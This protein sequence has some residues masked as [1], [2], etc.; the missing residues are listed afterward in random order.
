[1][2]KGKEIRRVPIDCH[3]DTRP[4]RSTNVSRAIDVSTIAAAATNSHIAVEIQ[5]KEYTPEEDHA[6]ATVA[7]SHAATG[8][9]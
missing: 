7:A 8:S 9:P 1:M 5:N 4:Y 3:I 6:A 2:S